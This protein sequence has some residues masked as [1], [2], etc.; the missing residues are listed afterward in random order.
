M[1]LAFLLTI[2][3][4]AAAAQPLRAVYT[5]E[6]LPVPGGQAGDTALLSDRFGLGRDYVFGSDFQNS[7]GL[8]GFLS[9]GGPGAFSALGNVGGVDALPRVEA[10]PL[11]TVGGLVLASATT[12]GTIRL[13]TTLPDA[14]FVAVTLDR[15]ITVTAPK[16]LALADFGD[17]GAHLFVNSGGPSLQRW[18]LVEDA[19]RINAIAATPIPLP[20]F[21]QAIAT[22]SG[23]RRVYASIGIGGVV[24]IDPLAV[25]PTVLN[26]IDAGAPGEIAA[27]LAV[28]PQRDGGALLITAVPNSLPI[29]DLFRVYQARPGLPALFLADV[30]FTAPDGG[31]QVR[32]GD[33][34]DVWPGHF[35]GTATSPRF[36]AGVFV[37]CDRQNANGA[38]YKLI[39]WDAIANAATPRLP[40]DV[41]GFVAPITPPAGPARVPFL[42]ATDSETASVAAVSFWPGRDALFATLD[43]VAAFGAFD[44][45]RELTL[46]L[47]AGVAR[48][49]DAVARP[50]RL[51]G[52]NASTLVV[53]TSTSND[54]G[55]LT[56]FSGQPDGG[57]TRI[58][59]IPLAAS[60]AGTAAV[61]DFGDAGTFVVLAGDE[62]ALH[63][64]ELTQTDAGLVVAPLADL[65]LPSVASSV[66]AFSAARVL[67]VAAGREGV[68]E[69]NPLDGGVR[70][71]VDAGA[72]ADVAA[73]LAL[74]AQSDGGL[75]LL[76]AVP[77]KDLFRVHRVRPEPTT[78]LTEFQVTMPDGGQLVRGAGWVDLSVAALGR[79]DGGAVWPAG[80]LALG[81]TT[82][83]G[84]VRLVSWAAVA[85]TVS[86]ALPIDTP[87][88]AGSLGG[89]A[90][91]G[92]GSNIVPAG[93]GRGGGDTIIQPPPPPGCCT[94]APSA[95]V[96]P[97]MGFL[98]WLRRF[99][100]RRADD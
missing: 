82:D 5:V 44:L 56:F 14:G 88:P 51:T 99:G 76:S 40:I 71:L 29:R 25:T 48:S 80:V 34:I 18:R 13:F 41:P 60:R 93:G 84:S 46:P 37:V 73:G 49:V 47:D 27:G 32:G 100:R 17:A 45:A 11:A 26:V 77:G 95:S 28:Y 8:Y 19:G 59:V 89:G 35:G 1:R 90:A 75:L 12:D 39:A 9:D 50:E 67:Y 61:A 36:D 72:A 4:T 57:L 20:F 31:R 98:Y 55:T 53:T 7:N 65:T 52:L 92:G 78:F 91:G 64:F 43:G 16:A 66:V 10:L 63:R 42:I 69:V 23:L 33:F 86:P 2:C 22:S 6:T 94:G 3:S 38:N 15:P 62:A 58:G 79:F 24:E 70:Q 54:A 68:L 87:G 74:Y 96:L 30:I 97:M 85:Q 81:T 83:G 21:A